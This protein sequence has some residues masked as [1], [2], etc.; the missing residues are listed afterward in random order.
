MYAA[1]FASQN[2]IIYSCIALIGTARSVRGGG[3]PDGAI[4]GTVESRKFRLSLVFSGGQGF[5]DN[6]APKKLKKRKNLCKNCAIKTFISVY[7]TVKIKNARGF[8]AGHGGIMNIEKAVKALEQVKTYV[9]ANSLDELDYAIEVLKKLE[10]DGITDPL[11][12]DFSVL[13]K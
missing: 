8:A 3:A 12:T 6:C 1:A 11:N 9:S 4:S 7:F 13:K 5:R 2:P 10:K